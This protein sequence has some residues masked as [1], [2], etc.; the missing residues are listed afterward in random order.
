MLEAGERQ[1]EHRFD[2]CMLMPCAVSCWLRETCGSC[3]AAR[4]LRSKDLRRSAIPICVTRAQRYRPRLSSPTHQAFAAPANLPRD[5]H[6]GPAEMNDRRGD[7]G[8]SVPR[9]RTSDA[10]SFVA[11][12]ILGPSSQESEPGQF[13]G[14][15]TRR[16]HITHIYNITVPDSPRRDCR[17]IRVCGRGNTGPPFGVKDWRGF[18]AQPHI[19]SCRTNSNSDAGRSRARTLTADILYE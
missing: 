19:F 2:K 14:T 12:L 8:A 1:S 18:I 3:K 7:Q 11:I 16:G 15:L 13:R 6:D 9:A 17:T 10:W 4:F 5:R